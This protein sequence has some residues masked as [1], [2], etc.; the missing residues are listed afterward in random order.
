LKKS[1]FFFVIKGVEFI[2][3]TSKEF[4]KEANSIIDSETRKYQ[5]FMC[6]TCKFYI[7]ENCTKRRIAKHC[8]KNGLKN[9]E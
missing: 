6:K 5:F 2:S 3:N 7:K 8:A 4:S 9:K 1:S